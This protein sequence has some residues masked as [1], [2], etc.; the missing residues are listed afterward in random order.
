MVSTMY[1]NGVRGIWWSKFFLDELEKK[2]TWPENPYLS[3]IKN[4]LN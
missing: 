2:H 1:E 4:D 3:L